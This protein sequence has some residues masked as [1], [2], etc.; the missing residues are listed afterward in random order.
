MQLI[1][2]Q[3]VTLTG[4]IVYTYMYVFKTY[5]FLPV[6]SV[7]RPIMIFCVCVK[8]LPLIE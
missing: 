6:E 7:E 5:I 4:I 8:I 1:F 3:N 2:S